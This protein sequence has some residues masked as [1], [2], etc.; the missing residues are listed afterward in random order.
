M[1]KTQPVNP[2]PAAPAGDRRESVTAL[3]S[4]WREGDA[5]A[6]SALF[7][8]VYRELRALARRHRRSLSAGETLRT[9]ALVHEAYLKLVDQPSMNILGRQHFFALAARVMRQVLVDAGR[10]RRAGKR[11]G[12]AI[13]LSLDEIGEPAVTCGGVDVQALDEALTHLGVV[14]ERLSRIVELR[15][16]CGLTVDET[17]DLVGAS[18]RTVKRDWRKA[19]AF[20]LAQIA[21]Q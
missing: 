7:P 19:R 21:A 9:T 3:L 1:A 10:R 12:E 4:S 13:H 6:V 20:L 15:V 5:D 16:F 8:V 11:G 18:P 17:A 14:D 2:D